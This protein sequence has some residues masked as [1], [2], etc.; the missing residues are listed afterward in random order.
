MCS[1]TNQPNHYR[2]QN[3]VKKKIKCNTSTGQQLYWL[4]EEV[5]NIGVFPMTGE[6][7]T[8]RA[9]KPQ[10]C[11]TQQYAAY[12]LRQIDETI[13]GDFG[14]VQKRKLKKWRSFLLG[15][16]LLAR[17]MKPYKLRATQTF[18]GSVNRTSIDCFVLSRMYFAVPM[19]SVFFC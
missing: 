1:H 5:N 2:N 7:I 18:S 11:V 9:Q 3:D 12:D 6:F 10:T 14:I 13:Y 17:A 8:H 4:L 16:F 15:F 19:N